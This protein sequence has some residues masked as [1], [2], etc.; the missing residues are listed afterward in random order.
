LKFT[1][2]ASELDVLESSS[3]GK[4]FLNTH[5]P[6]SSEPNLEI[7][8]TY[9]INH[10]ELV[11]IDDFISPNERAVLAALLADSKFTR[12]ESSR[13]DTEQQLHFAAEFEL[14]DL[15][16]NKLLKRVTDS[17]SELFKNKKY[18]A[19]RVYCNMGFYGDSSFRHRDCSTNADDVTALIY[20]NT[21]WEA[22]WAGETIFFDD[23]SDSI[24][25]I[26]PKPGRIV[27]F[28]G[29]IAHR[30]GVPARECYEPRYTL[31]FKFKSLPE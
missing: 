16:D 6:L 14:K 24:Y 15:V 3:C 22:D 7:K 5:S 17:V 8:A 19:Y 13:G 1:P 30:S 25:A 11:V 26:N 4:I 27:F 20:A 9:K 31:A 23:Q 10:R 29:A 12:T 28:H 2:A 21:R 18:E